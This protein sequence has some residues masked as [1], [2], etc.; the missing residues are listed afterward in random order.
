[1]VGLLF[2]YLELVLD[3]NFPVVA[4]LGNCPVH[5]NHLHVELQR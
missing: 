4:A 3:H 2:F 5:G 1:M